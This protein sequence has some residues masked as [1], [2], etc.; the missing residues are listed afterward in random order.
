MSSVIQ[1]SLEIH[2]MSYTVLDQVTV[3]VYLLQIWK[4]DLIVI[5]S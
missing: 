3:E 2:K 1:K 4:F 5:L